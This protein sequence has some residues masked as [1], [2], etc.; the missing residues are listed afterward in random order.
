MS[1]RDLLLAWFFFFCLLMKC[2]IES[3]IVVLALVT[4]LKVSR[5]KLCHYLWMTR[6]LSVLQRLLLTSMKEKV[7]RLHSWL[8]VNRLK[9]NLGKSK[10][11]IFSWCPVF[12]PWIN[13]IVK[14]VWI[15]KCVLS[16]KYLGVYIDEILSF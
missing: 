4:W 8:R 11:V 2:L 16:I 14:N 6:W 1:T 13:E 7:D 12:Y 10:F 15:L 3:V 9:L 5:M